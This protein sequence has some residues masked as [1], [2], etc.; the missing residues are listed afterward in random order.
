VLAAKRRRTEARPD[1]FIEPPPPFFLF[2]TVDSTNTPSGPRVHLP[3]VRLLK[4]V[5]ED[6]ELKRVKG[7]R[8]LVLLALVQH[9][10]RN[11]DAVWPS[12]RR[13]ADFTRLSPRQTLRVLE[14]LEAAGLIERD[15]RGRGRIYRMGAAIQ[16]ATARIGDAR[17]MYA[18]PIGD[19]GDTPQ[20]TPATEIGDTGDTRSIKEDIKGSM[21]SGGGLEGWDDFWSLYPRK[22]AKKDAQAAFRQTRKVR[23]PAAVLLAALS[24]FTNS[25]EWQK[26]GGRYVPYPATWLRDERW[27]DVEAT[28]EPSAASGPPAPPDWQ[29]VLRVYLLMNY[30]DA[31]QRAFD[32]WDRVPDW[33]RN[34]VRELARWVEAEPPPEGWAAVISTLRDAG[35]LPAGDAF[36][37]WS[38]VPLWLRAQ[39]HLLLNQAA[40]ET[41]K[42]GDKE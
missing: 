31:E 19:T 21:P 25:K 15:K 27:R 24:N 39:V 5:W 10:S 40:E 4:C 42:Q 26:E 13:L 37:A 6:A 22:V 35:E 2:L 41:D 7:S 33:M 18:E 14:E 36:A 3:N 38:A 11:T 17:D 9:T 8:L 1:S 12:I 30:P 29:R 23:P 34:D 16:S 32:S 28:A 20:V